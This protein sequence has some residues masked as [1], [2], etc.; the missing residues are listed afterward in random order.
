M[1]KGW[2]VR[3][4][5]LFEKQALKEDMLGIRTLVSDTDLF[6]QRTKSWFDEVHCS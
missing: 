6:I 5:T 3:T 2:I 1:E 4:K